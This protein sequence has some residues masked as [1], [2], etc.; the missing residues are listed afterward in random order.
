ME[1]EAYSKLLARSV[2]NAPL[3]IKTL[4]EFTHFDRGVLASED[5]AEC[6]NFQ[7]K[8]GHL[9]EDV[10]YESLIN[11]EKVDSVKRGSQVFRLDEKQRR[12]TIGELD[13]ILK[14]GAR[15]IHL[16]LAVKFY[17]AVTTHDSQE[18][19]WYGPDARD[20]WDRKRA[21]M[22]DHQLILSRSHESVHLVKS[23]T[24]SEITDVQHLIY[25]CFFDEVGKERAQAKDS[26]ITSPR[27][28]WMRRHQIQL[29]MHGKSLWHIPK[30]L[31]PCEIDTELL[32]V[33]KRVSSEELIELSVEQ[34]IMFTDGEQRYFVVPDEWCA[35]V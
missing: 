35:A 18:V 15:I 11:G 17:M 19:I 26:S 13:F 32:D 10:L 6:F 24:N 28:I 21:R 23:L 20:H 8:L 33:L 5:G 22:L 7:Q 4:G 34:S 16:E 25:G 12:Q 29:S 3:L 1:L 27:G 14:I 31:W 9:Y 2:K 30:V